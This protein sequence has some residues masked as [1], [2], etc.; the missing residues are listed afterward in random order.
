MDDVDFV[1]EIIA[2]AGKIAMRHY[3]NVKPSWKENR[4]YVTAAD[5]AVQE[6]LMEAIDRAYPEDG[7]IAEEQDLHKQPAAGGR[8]WAI[9]PIDGTAAFSAGLPIWGIAIALVVRDQAQAGFFYI[10]TTGDLFHT[11]SDGRVWRNDQPLTLLPPG[12]LHPETSLLIASRPHQDYVISPTYPGKLRNLGSTMAHLA[13][14]ATGNAAAALVERVYIWD[15]AAGMAML[16]HNGGT[17]L[18]M[19]GTPVELGPLRTGA[20]MA[21]P[22]LAGHPQ[23]V[24]AFASLIQYRPHDGG[25]G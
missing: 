7:I 14:V 11:T 9:D 4:T 24:A 18:Y 5:L 6:Y 2:S 23:T 19:D 3:L 15:I 22:I 16:Q 25:Q 13:Y 12:P 17:M 21:Q 8:L 10:P 20:R 1:K